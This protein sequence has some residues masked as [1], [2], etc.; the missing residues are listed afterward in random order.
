MKFL[1]I[2]SCVF[3]TALV[4]CGDGNSGSE[5]SSQNF[6]NRSTPPEVFSQ[7]HATS[8]EPPWPWIPPRT[9]A[10]PE[11]VVIRDL[12]RGHGPP[13]EPR[14]TFVANFISFKYETG[15]E[16]EVHW[17]DAAF[18][19][20]W[21]GVGLTKG[22]DIGLAGMQAGGRRELIVPSELAYDSGTLVYLIELVRL[23]G[24]QPAQR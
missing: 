7:L 6:G 22:W 9:G 16:T 10:P 8:G 3:L 2:L 4:A 17:G 20:H 5:D 11:R 21:R 19:W 15:R 24:R 12:R 1:Y 23:G 18:Q 14:Q 13:I